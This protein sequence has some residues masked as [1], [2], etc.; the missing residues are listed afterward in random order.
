M[1]Q[2]REHP[3]Y[4]TFCLTLQSFKR[5]SLLHRRPLQ[6]DLAFL[7]PFA[8]C[9]RVSRRV[10]FGRRRRRRRRCRRCIVSP[11]RRWRPP[12]NPSNQIICVPI[13]PVSQC[14]MKGEVHVFQESCLLINLLKN[15]ASPL[16]TKKSSGGVERNE[17][18]EEQMLLLF[19]VGGF[20]FCR[21]FVA[22]EVHPKS[23]NQ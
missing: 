7:P 11:S 2:T 16:L 9:L 4:N 18:E 14:C 21:P 8:P 12:S 6:L 17:E 19:S 3:Q 15:R 20:S 22:W 23:E 13:P 10:V 1:C 5:S